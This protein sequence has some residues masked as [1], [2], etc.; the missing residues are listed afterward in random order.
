MLLHFDMALSY[1][2]TQR[3]VRVYNL[4]KQELVKK[5]FTNAKWVSSMAVHPG[6]MSTIITIITNIITIIT[7][8]I[9]IV[10]LGAVPKPIAHGPQMWE[11]RSKV[12]GQ[13]KPL[14]YTNLYLSLPSLALSINLIG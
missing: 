4:L 3:Y 7:I 1:F 12:P 2:Q 13:V 11:I 5:L 9:I 8:T 10:Q 6:G 14:S